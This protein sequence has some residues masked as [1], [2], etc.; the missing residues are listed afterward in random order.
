MDCNQNQLE[1]ETLMLCICT[2]TIW[3]RVLIAACVNEEVTRTSVQFCSLLF[4]SYIR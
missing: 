4:S 3:C 2:T 1:N